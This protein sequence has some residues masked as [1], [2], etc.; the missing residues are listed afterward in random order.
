M[1]S[2]EDIALSLLDL[3]EFKQ[4]SQ[5]TTEATLNLHTPVPNTADMWIHPGVPANDI[6]MIDPRAALVKLTAKQLML[7]S[8]RIVSNQTEAVYATL[9]TGFSKIYNDSV[10]V[11][12]TTKAFASY[13]FPEY[14]NKDPYMLVNLE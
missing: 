4:R 9:T 14:M 12:D 7:E 11:L 13:G 2:A 5:G 1:I 3:P 8:E 6:V 10:L